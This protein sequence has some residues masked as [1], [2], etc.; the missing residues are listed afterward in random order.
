MVSDAGSA[1]D[2]LLEL[3]NLRTWYPA[4]RGVLGG[5]GAWVKAV[6]DVSF[7]IRRGETFGLVGESGCGKT[8]L[9]RSIL[10]LEQA[11]SGQVMF[12]G[13]DVLQLSPGRLKQVRRNM[14]AI[15][16][17]PHGSLDPR[18]KVRDLIAE[19]LVVQGDL[20]RD[21][22]DA[23]VAELVDVVG[24]RREHLDRYPHE[25]SGGQRQ[26]IGIARALALRPKF[27]LA[28]EPVSAL[29]LSVQ[30]QVLNLLKDLQT[31]FGLTYLFIA[32]DLSV[33]EYISDRVGVMYLGRIVELARAEVLY[34]DPRMP[35]T[36]ALLSAIPGH[37]QVTGRRRIILGGD[38]PS[39][40]NPPSGCPFRTRCWLAQDV[41]RDNVPKL[42]EVAPDH[43]AACHFADQ[44]AALF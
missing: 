7:T 13:E 8:T 16:Q 42:R 2:V 26:R 9:G 10:R 21:E 37:E 35:Y 41:C 36:Q 31:S 30:S 19:G 29:D 15:F 40:L 34:D 24:L 38:V 20:R 1:D 44:Q 43:F 14:Q 6:D 18:M 4:G 22:R 17:D 39:P 23:R 11:R 25:F 3:R 27:V 12:D 33:V 5:N 28:D 32:H